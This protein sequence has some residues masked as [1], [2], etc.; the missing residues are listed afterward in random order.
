MR[1]FNQRKSNFEILFEKIVRKEF[2][3][4]YQNRIFELETFCQ[5]FPRTAEKITN[6]ILSGKEYAD[7]RKALK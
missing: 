7:S 1:E 2:P 4:M 3:F 6:K 5:V